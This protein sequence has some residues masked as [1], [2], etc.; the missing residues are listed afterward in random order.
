[1]SR[2]KPAAGGKKLSAV[3]CVLIACFSSF[4][5]AQKAP[6]NFVVSG[7]SRNCGNVVMPAIAEGTQKDGAVFYWHLGD[8]RA[9]FA[10]DEDYL[11][12]P[13]H[14][15]QPADMKQ[16]LDA[17][18]DDFIENQ[19]KFFGDTP[20]YVGIGNHEVIKPKTRGEFASK[21]SRWLDAPALKKQ[22]LADNPQDQAVRTYF[23]W[24]QGGVDFIY[25]D[26]A[27]GDQFDSAQMAWLEDVLKRAR[28]NDDVQALVVGM[29][30]ALPESMASAH[31]MS[32]FVVG[33][34]SGRQAYG[35]LLKF[36]HQTKKH[37]Y[38]LASHSHFYMSGIFDDDYWKEHGGVLP[39]WIIGTGGAMRYPLPPS[40]NRAKEARQKVYGYLLGRVHDDGSIDFKF[41]EVKRRD[42][43]EAV[44]QRYTPD[45]VDYCFDQ[46]TDF[47][48]RPV[49]EQK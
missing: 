12:E 14:R 15:G 7:D 26:N 49:P 27:S 21:F 6:W 23:H 8:L 29:H 39:G 22:R 38:T 32:D 4:A 17:A 19:L 28:S 44:A 42:V 25:L 13:E 41:H 33:T 1:M 46:N 37:V 20:V 10:P 18:W 5:F 16:Y 30:A 24:I 31:S 11:H 34:E 35:D 48:P 2:H 36:N 3:C 40:A 45:F 43:P 9:I 47:K